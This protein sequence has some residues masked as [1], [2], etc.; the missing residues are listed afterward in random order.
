MQKDHGQEECPTEGKKQAH[1]SRIRTQPLDHGSGKERH[2]HESKGY[3][4]H[5]DKGLVSQRT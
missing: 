3:S 1:P 5:H 4:E 2:Y